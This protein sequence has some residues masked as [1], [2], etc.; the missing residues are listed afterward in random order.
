[1]WFDATLPHRRTPVDGS[2]KDGARGTDQ[3]ACVSSG[4]Y[5]AL[6][7]PASIPKGYRIRPETPAAL[8]LGMLIAII[9]VIAALIG[10]LVYALSSNAKAQ[11]IGRALM[12]C[13]FLVTLF[14]AAQRV[15]K[16]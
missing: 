16:L 8:R 1:M 2:E 9:P 12:W 5:E 13:G 6:H 7:P 4:A 3:L 14:V 15:V 10:V 11:E